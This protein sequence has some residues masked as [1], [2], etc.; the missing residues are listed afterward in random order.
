MILDV[1]NTKASFDQALNGFFQESRAGLRCSYCR[2]NINQIVTT[3]IEAGPQV[4]K[5]K[6]AIFRND[7]ITNPVTN[8]VTWQ[9]Y[10]VM[11]TLQHPNTLDLT[12]HKLHN[13]LPLRYTLSSVI[14]HS[15][16]G[17]PI[18]SG[19][20]IASVR[21]PGDNIRCISD[22]ATENFTP[23]QMSG[24][25]QRP[26]RVSRTPKQVYILTYLKHDVTLTRAQRKALSLESEMI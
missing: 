4:L 14:S 16:S 7:P 26:V 23:A 8:T 11:H 21:G 19:H 10:K 25:P 18:C 20:Y 22:P 2:I 13:S 3:R 6:L 17:T 5:I 12:A 15:G 9:K 24:S 1:T